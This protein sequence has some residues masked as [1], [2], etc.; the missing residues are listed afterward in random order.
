MLSKVLL[1]S[2]KTLPFTIFLSRIFQMQFLFSEISTSGDLCMQQIIILNSAWCVPWKILFCW[3]FF[4]IQKHI[5]GNAI[6]GDR[7]IWKILLLVISRE[8]ESLICCMPWKILFLDLVS[9][10]KVA[11][12]YSCLWYYHSCNKNLL[13]PRNTRN[14]SAQSVL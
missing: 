10:F 9:R 2:L 3:P 14:N 7:V 8:S 12:K 6:S 13:M 5:N 11:I 4:T 1:L